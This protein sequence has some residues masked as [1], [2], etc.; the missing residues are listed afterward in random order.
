[1]AENNSQAASNV[2]EFNR[3]LNN[4]TGFIHEKY[5]KHYDD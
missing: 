1:M 5:D 4:N 3:F 2:S